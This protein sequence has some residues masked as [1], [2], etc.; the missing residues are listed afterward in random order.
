MPKTRRDHRRNCQN[1]KRFDR[2]GQ[3][4][5]H[6]LERIRSGEADPG[7]TT[8]RC[9]RCRGWHIG[10]GVRSMERAIQEGRLVF[11]GSSDA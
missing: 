1:H 4:F 5:N 3:A 11:S 10:G 9:T 7:M 2:E 8:Y 6:L